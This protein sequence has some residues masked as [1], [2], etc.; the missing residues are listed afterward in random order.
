VSDYECD[1]MSSFHACSVIVRDCGEGWGRGGEGEGELKGRGG[2]YSTNQGQ[3]WTSICTTSFKGGFPSKLR[4][5]IAQGTGEG[6][7]G[8]ELRII[9]TQDIK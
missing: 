8:G 9:N 2:Q 3:V 5:C 6:S 7:R 1:V 4:G